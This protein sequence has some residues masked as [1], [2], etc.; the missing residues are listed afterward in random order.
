MGRYSKIKSNYVLRKKHLVTNRGVIYERDWVTLGERHMFEPGKRPI[1]YDGNFVFTDNTRINTKKR[2]TYGKFVASWTYDDVKDALPQSNRVDVNMR[3]TDM[4][5]FAYYG[6]CKDLVRT[7][8]LDIVNWFP[9]QIK[10]SDTKFLLNY[11]ETRFYTLINL[12][13]IDF[14]HELDTP[15]PYDNPMRYLATS[16]AKYTINGSY[17]T[18]YK[19]EMLQ[20][21]YKCPENNEGNL[22]QTVTITDFEENQHVLYGYYVDGS[23]VFVTEDPELLIKPNDTFIENYFRDLDGFARLLLTRETTPLYKSRFVTPIE[24]SEDESY[25][26]VMREY[27]FP[28]DGYCVSVNTPAFFSYVNDLYKIA[29]IFDNT[30]CDNLYRNMTHEAIKN[31][32][33]TYTRDYAEGEE[34]DYV[35]GGE[36]MADFLRVTGRMF[37]DLKRYIDGIRMTN[38]VSYDR[39]NNIDDAE[40]SDRLELEGWDI[41]STIPSIVTSTEGS[42]FVNTET[43]SN[44]DTAIDEYAAYS[45][46]DQYSYKYPIQIKL[47]EER[48]NGV[49]YKDGTSLLPVWFSGLNTN[50]YTANEVDIEF[51]RQMMMCSKRLLQTKGTVQGVEMILG[52]FGLG[53]GI[54]Y[55]I[56][57]G[58]KKTIPRRLFAMSELGMTSFLDIERDNVKAL[59]YNNTGDMDR[60]DPYKDIP[61]GDITYDGFPYMIPLYDQNKY[62]NGDIYFQSKGG[63]A[64]HGNSIEEDFTYTETLSYLRT[65]DTLT[66]LYNLNPRDL[67]KGSI[68]YVYSLIDPMEEADAEEYPDI[69]DGTPSP[70]HFFT[71]INEYSPQL[72]ASWREVIMDEE[73]ERFDPDDEA[74]RRALYLDSIISANNGNNPHVGYGFYDMGAT[75]D[76]FMN[77]PFSYFYGNYDVADDVMTEMVSYEFPIEPYGILAETDGV[78]DEDGNYIYDVSKVRSITECR[79]KV[80]KEKED[81]DEAKILDKYFLNDK[82]IVLKNLH[83][84]NEVYNQ[85]FMNVIFPYLSQMMPSTAML[86]LDGFKKVFESEAYSVDEEE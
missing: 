6:S 39:N 8:I 38:T 5:D 32:D 24:K 83:E 44:S 48:S 7:T 12:F 45:C 37:D 4:R 72:T 78:Q 47:L 58:Y 42:G 52:M 84:D 62:Y 77:H 65:V 1:Y 36:I 54:D 34:Q 61:M 55:E 40:L 35:V 74:Y 50:N 25:V 60:D 11:E 81:S 10:A 70:S 19:V 9:G 23:V 18:D 68:V 20:F 15:T 71:L 29:E 30:W 73:D 66:Q 51:M 16:W 76:D 28:S 13:E 63:W 85:Y 41:V 59:R 14:V 3:S 64:K 17:I 69:E 31:F 82:I 22:V 27:T 56:G 33:W 2:H 49:T 67:S 26:Y 80:S 46:V 75:Y 53:R 43:I 21:D 57:E 86:R 79:Q